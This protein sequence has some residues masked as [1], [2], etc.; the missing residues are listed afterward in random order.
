M[1]EWGQCHTVE[2]YVQVAF[3]AVHPVDA[4]P[5]LPDELLHLIAGLIRVSFDDLV[6]FWSA[7][8]AEL[9][10]FVLELQGAE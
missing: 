8:A 2:E 6:K 3:S 10:G 9:M 1:V 4:Q 7:R 5:L